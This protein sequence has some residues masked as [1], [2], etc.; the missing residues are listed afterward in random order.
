MSLVPMLRSISNRILQRQKFIMVELLLF[1]ISFII[2]LLFSLSAT[3][4]SYSWS[5][6]CT[7]VLHASCYS[8]FKHIP[9]SR[10]FI[11]PSLSL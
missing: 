8:E 1:S 3:N 11:N 4:T 10:I 6:L 2:A 7:N 5:L 9:N